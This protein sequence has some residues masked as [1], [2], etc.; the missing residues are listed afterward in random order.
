MRNAPGVLQQLS[1]AAVSL[2]MA[3]LLLK[4]P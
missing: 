1:Q 4:Q 3:R 2:Q